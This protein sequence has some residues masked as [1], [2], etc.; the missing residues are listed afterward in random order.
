MRFSPPP[1]RICF[2]PY[3]LFRQGCYQ[4][5][6]HFFSAC[7]DLVMVWV[8]ISALL[9]LHIILGS[10]V[11]HKDETHPDRFH[12]H[13]TQ[14]WGHWG[15][16]FHSGAWM[17]LKRAASLPGTYTPGTTAPAHHKHCQYTKHSHITGTF[18]FIHVQYYFVTL[19]LCWIY[20]SKRNALYCTTLIW[21]LYLLQILVLH[22]TWGKLIK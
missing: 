5:M 11:K 8:L 17:L 22:S 4:N 2:H 15:G 13:H 10:S 12:G 7:S 20:I 16:P 3:F 21:Q 1:T 18:P 19:Y 9:V 6:A 14:I